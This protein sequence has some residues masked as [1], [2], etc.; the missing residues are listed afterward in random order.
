[1]MALLQVSRQ[2][3]R[4]EVDDSLQGVS[5]WVKKM[6]AVSVSDDPVTGVCASPDATAHTQTDDG[7]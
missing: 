6:S 1:M 4:V 2:I 3:F 7:I 5:V